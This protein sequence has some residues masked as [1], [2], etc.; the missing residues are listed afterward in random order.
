MLFIEKFL[1]GTSCGTSSTP[2]HNHA[3]AK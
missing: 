1:G 2:S 3:P